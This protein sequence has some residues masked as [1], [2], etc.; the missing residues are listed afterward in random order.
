VG[1]GDLT[2]PLE[3]RA[4]LGGGLLPQVGRPL[5]LHLR[6]DPAG[7]RDHL[8]ATLGHLHQPRPGVGG[9]GHPADVAAPLAPEECSRRLRAMVGSRRT[10]PFITPLEPLLDVLV[11][12][13]DITVPLGRERPVPPVPAA[14]AAR[15]AWAMGFPFHARRRLAGLRLVATDGDLVLGDGAPVEG[16]T[17]DLLL[18]TG[19][20]ATVDRLSG[21]GAHRLPTARVRR[22]GFPRSPA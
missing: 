12:G 17:G 15:R 11:H 7:H 6:L 4:Q 20:T 8:P 14:V 10:A 9:V 3:R 1:V 22:D 16:T 19:R 2:Q 18:V 21:E 13:Q 5:G